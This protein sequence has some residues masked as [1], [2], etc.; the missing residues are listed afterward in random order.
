MTAAA[1]LIVGFSTAA[2]DG[3]GAPGAYGVIIAGAVVA[4]GAIVHSLTTKKNAVLPRVRHNTNFVIALLTVVQRYLTTRTT[5]FFSIGSFLNSL[6]LL[7]I[8]YLLP[9]FFQGVSNPL[10]P[11]KLL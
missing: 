3:F 7:S 2:D 6:L 8:T 11:E 1:L 4:V 9:Q 5:V 10:R